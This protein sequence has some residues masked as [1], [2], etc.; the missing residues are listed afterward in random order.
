MKL[1]GVLKGSM[2]LLEV[3]W[4]GGQNEPSMP[5]TSL[6]AVHPEHAWFLLH[7][8]L[9]TSTHQHQGAAG[10]TLSWNVRVMG[11]GVQH[12]LLTGVSQLLTEGPQ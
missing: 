1:W 9:R 2:S 10:L 8:G 7:G 4:H 6:N 12:A 5:S 3:R 11:A